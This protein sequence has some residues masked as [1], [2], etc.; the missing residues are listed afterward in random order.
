MPIHQTTIRLSRK[1]RTQAEAIV[2][3]GR[4]NSRVITRARIL[5]RSHE[6]ASKSAIAGE[7][8]I[9]QSTVRRVRCRYHAQGIEQALF[10][11]PRTGRPPKLDEKAEAHL[12]ALACSDAPEGRDHWTLELLR[13]QMIKD[14]Q[15]KTIST[16]AL[17]KRMQ[18]HDLKPWREKNVVHPE[19]HAGIHQPDGGGA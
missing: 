1:E 13:K 7:L 2:H 11:D 19:H 12:I 14:K 4:H 10:D 3:K 18:A 9:N 6:G 15:V 8:G 16:V 17:W 5:L